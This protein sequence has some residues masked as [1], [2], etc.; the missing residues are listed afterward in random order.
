MDA[1][2][3]FSF[4]NFPDCCKMLK[5][6]NRMRLLS[7]LSTWTGYFHLIKEKSG[8]THITDHYACTAKNIINQMPMKPNKILWASLLGGCR[9]H[10]NLE[11]VSIQ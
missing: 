6:V 7:S 11:L 4:M 1:S 10:G 8:L 3:R 2:T 5:M 9:I